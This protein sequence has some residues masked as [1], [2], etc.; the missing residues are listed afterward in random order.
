MIKLILTDFSIKE[1]AHKVVALHDTGL[2]LELKVGLT[3][4]L[5]EVIDVINQ[6]AMHL[7]IVAANGFYKGAPS[8]EEKKVQQPIEIGAGKEGVGSTNGAGDK[9]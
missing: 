4:P 2:A 5:K 3:D 7:E 1:Q 6:A 8:G 9:A